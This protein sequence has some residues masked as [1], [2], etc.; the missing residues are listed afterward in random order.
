MNK[1]RRS[2]WKRPSTWVLTPVALIL[3]CIG[4]LT[5][6]E[7]QASRAITTELNQLRSEGFP[8][9]NQT[10]QDYFEAT[11]HR[12]G[13]QAWAEVAGL[14]GDQWLSI[15]ASD[16]QYVGSSKIPT[17]LDPKQPWEQEADVA[18]Y[19]VHVRPIIEKIHQATEYPTPVW[20]P[21]HFDGIGTLLGPIQQSRSISRTLQL[22]AEYAI[23]TQESERALQDI[24]SMDGVAKAYDWDIFVVAKFVASAAMMVKYNTICRSLY[25]SPWSI[26]QLEELRSLVDTPPDV[27]AQWPS[28]IASE[29]ATTLE[30]L[31]DYESL[32]RWNSQDHYP[33]LVALLMSLPSAKLSY[34]NHTAAW[35]SLGGDFSSML[36]ASNKLTHEQIAASSDFPRIDNIIDGLFGSWYPQAVQSLARNEDFRRFTKTALAIKQ[37]HLS[38]QRWPDRL[39]ELETVGLNASDW[40]TIDRGQFGYEAKDNQVTIWTYHSGDAIPTTPSTDEDLQYTTTV[41]R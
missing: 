29:R 36:E 26:D 28:L 30:S 31:G 18:E 35:Q 3:L 23:Y 19:L 15:L 21:I 8:V 33:R 6:R 17:F 1:K 41:I 22:D 12:E 27:V 20:Q 16:L 11:T 32:R 25:S 5:V 10:T 9:D 40:T 4:W 39:G 2:F 7:V 38:N 37:F 24:R 14:L 13:T 34:L